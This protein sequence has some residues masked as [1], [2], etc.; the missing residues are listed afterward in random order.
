M[1]KLTESPLPKV[2]TKVKKM[3]KYSRV[4]I[5]KIQLKLSK[6]EKNV[7]KKKKLINFE[8]DN[9]RSKINFIVPSLQNQHQSGFGYS[10]V[11]Y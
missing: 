2:F 10:V 1:S 7:I 6:L 8:N 9:D 5:V 4:E 3:S 11:K